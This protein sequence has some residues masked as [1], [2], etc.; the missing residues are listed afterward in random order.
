MVL[1]NGSKA[2]RNQQSICNRTNVCGG[3]K[4]SGLAPSIGYFIQSNP[5]QLRTAQSIP[6]V[7]VVSTTV[8]TQRVGYTATHGG[9]M[10]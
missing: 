9:N 8:Q 1:S 7:C 6:K 2:A 3:M 4:K 10:G 5:R